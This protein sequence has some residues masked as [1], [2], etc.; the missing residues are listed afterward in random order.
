M[1]ERKT[2]FDRI[3]FNFN[4][5]FTKHPPFLRHFYSN[6][7]VNRVLSHLLGFTVNDELRKILVDNAGKLKVSSNIENWPTSPYDVKPSGRSISHNYA[8]TA[9][10][11]G[12]TDRDITIS[13]GKIGYLYGGRVTNPDGGARN[14]YVAIRDTIGVIIQ[15][16]AIGAIPLN[17]TMVYPDRIGAF[18]SIMTTNMP[19]P[20][21]PGGFVRI[22]WSGMDGGN[23]SSNA[24]SIIEVDV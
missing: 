13:A 1:V 15:Y 24:H 2:I 22:H 3:Q 6:N 12:V 4:Q 9:L 14:I 11:V 5:I 18:F 21:E 20:I 7:H 8:S 17:T 19:M 10:G 16:I 23:N